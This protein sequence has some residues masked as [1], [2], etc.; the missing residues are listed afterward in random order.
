MF[1][2]RFL[3]KHNIFGY[4]DTGAISSSLAMPS[5]SLSL[6][7]LPSTVGSF[8]AAAASVLSESALSPSLVVN[9]LL[10]T[11][12]PHP[13]H[14]L[15]QGKPRTQTAVFSHTTHRVGGGLGMGIAHT[16]TTSLPFPTQ[17]SKKGI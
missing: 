5:S 3:K 9:N 1:T 7:T 14:A 13:G 8:G 17:L 2:C 15:L 10:H 12:A 4:N 6:D 11:H 16:H